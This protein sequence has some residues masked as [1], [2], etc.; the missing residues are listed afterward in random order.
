MNI[1][2]ILSTAF[3]ATLVFATSL[4]SAGLLAQTFGVEELPA[5]ESPDKKSKD[6]VELVINYGNGNEARLPSHRGMVEPISMQ[7]NQLMPFSLQFPGDKVQLPVAIA[8]LEG[9]EVIPMA[10]V[11]DIA[12]SSGGIFTFNYERADELFVDQS[13]IIRFGYRSSPTVGV[14][15]VVVHL[16]G[17]QH[18]LEFHVLPASY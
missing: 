2:Q 16:P 17:E 10:S 13:G 14:Y 15:R 8:P 12:V 18:I 1:K 3:I 6:P 4:P 9:G 11:T 7:P 5:E